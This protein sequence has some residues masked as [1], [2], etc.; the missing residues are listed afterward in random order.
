GAGTGDLR[1]M[2]GG[3]EAAAGTGG[4]VDDEIAVPGADAVHHVAVEV[5]LHR[6]PARG[7]IADMDMRNRGPRLGRLQR[8]VR[9]LLWG[10]RQV[11]RLLRLGD[12]AG[13]GAGDESLVELGW[14]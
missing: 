4:E 8:A 7:G 11:W 3:D 13:D 10:D 12:V 14:H 5:G 1:I 9:D 6:R 2:L